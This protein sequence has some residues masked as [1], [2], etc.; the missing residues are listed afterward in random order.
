MILYNN[1]KQER[2]RKINQ[3]RL[4]QHMIDEVKS[5]VVLSKFKD[6]FL[7]PFSL[8]SKSLHGLPPTLIL[9]WIFGVFGRYICG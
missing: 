2:R 3:D 6:N 8:I 5:K 4:P 7:L 1:Y 9:K